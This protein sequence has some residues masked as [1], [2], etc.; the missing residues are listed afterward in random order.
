[1][2]VTSSPKVVH[3]G[4]D[5]LVIGVKSTDE[6]SYNVIFKPFVERVKLTNS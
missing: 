2:V 6:V 3:Q 4:I 1:M 5:T